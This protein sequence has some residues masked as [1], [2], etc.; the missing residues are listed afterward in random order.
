MLVPKSYGGAI[1]W[2]E[3]GPLALKQDRALTLKQAGSLDL[4]RT[5]PLILEQ[6]GPVALEHECYSTA[7]PGC[8]GSLAERGFTVYVATQFRSGWCGRTRPVDS[9]LLRGKT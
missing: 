3:A 6:T 8:G 4:E 5:K 2:D 7:R 1:G 9:G